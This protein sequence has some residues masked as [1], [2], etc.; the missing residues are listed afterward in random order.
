MSKARSS[1]VQVLGHRLLLIDPTIHPISRCSWQWHGVPCVSLVSSSLVSPSSSSFHP[2]STPQAVA[3][4]AGG[5]WCVIQGAISLSPPPR[6]PPLIVPCHPH[7]VQCWC[8]SLSPRLP[9]P[10][11]PSCL[12]LHLLV[13]PSL[14]SSLSSSLPHL[15]PNPSLSPWVFMVGPWRRRQGRLMSLCCYQQLIT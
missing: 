9:L 3:R 4:E 10:P 13:S 2:L 1:G 7:L 15:P 6:H 14:S 12:P 5:E 11:P 8:P